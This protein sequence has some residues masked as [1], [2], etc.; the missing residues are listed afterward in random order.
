MDSKQK[1][2]KVELSIIISRMSDVQ[3]GE[4]L[5]KIKQNQEASYFNLSSKERASSSDIPFMSS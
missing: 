3:A 1:S 4:L 5:K 2:A